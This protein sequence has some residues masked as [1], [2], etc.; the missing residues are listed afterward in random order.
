MK[1]YSVFDKKAGSFSSPIFMINDAIAKRS[2]SSVVF[3]SK[4]TLNQFPDDYALYCVGDFD[5]VTGSLSPVILDG[6]VVPPRF[7][8]EIKDFFQNDSVN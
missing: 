8:C 7:I 4:S 2:L 3:D 5:D 6:Q 1:A